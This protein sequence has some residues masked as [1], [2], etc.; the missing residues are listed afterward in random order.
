MAK[1]ETSVHIARPVAEVWGYLTD[2]RNE[3][4]WST[5][6]VDTTYSGPT[7]GRRANLILPK[8]PLT[9]R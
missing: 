7:P 3:K 1:I 4:E 2:L 8:S 6:V 9:E 5:E